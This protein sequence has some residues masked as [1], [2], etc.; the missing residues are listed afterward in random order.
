MRIMAI[1]LG[2]ARTGIALCD[3]NEIL[4]SPFCVL[5]AMGLTP[6]TKRVL[7]IIEAEQVEKVLVGLPLRTDGKESEMTE[8]ARSFAEFL[9]KRTSAEV[10][11]LNEA[12]TTVIAA[13]KL[14]ENNISAKKQ[15][16]LI[17]AAAA[18]VLLQSYID[19]D[20][21]VG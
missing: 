10:L 14:H 9:R 16:K 11:L 13:Q 18:A 21:A 1:D 17:D 6:L 8:K 15:R 2:L 12:Y 5:E 19:S 4:A 20:P 7:E 3:K